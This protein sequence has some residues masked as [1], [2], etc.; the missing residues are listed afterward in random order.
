VEEKIKTAIENGFETV[1]IPDTL[2]IDDKY[3]EKTLR[4]K[5]VKEL[6]TVIF[7]EKIIQGK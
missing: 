1:I 4:I 3:L 2:T 5:T 6:V 7:L